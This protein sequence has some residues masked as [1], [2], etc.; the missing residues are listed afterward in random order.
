VSASRITR[1]VPTGHEEAPLTDD[2]MLSVLSPRDRAVPC[3]RVNFVTTLDG[4]STS[5]GVSGSLGGPADGRVFDL[6]RRVTDVVV[7][8]AG[9]V[10]DEGY[11]AMRLGDDAV[12]WR[13][14]AGLAPQPVF[15]LVS[16]SLRLD[17][18]S[19]VFTEAPVRPLVLTTARADA[20]ARRAL[21][22]VADVV[23]CGEERVDPRLL[24]DA[25]VERGLPQMHCE[26][27]P[28]LFGDLVRGDAVDELFLTLAPMLEGGHG[29]RV[30]QGAD[31]E[32]SSPLR[33]L[34]LA[35]VLQDGD[36]LLTWYVRDRS[37]DDGS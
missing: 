35:H 24:R 18:A 36:E 6:L 32:E 10:R 13:E 5:E 11:G 20:A 21:E 14:H 22:R 2:E 9:T 17:P 7:V 15:A 37:R 25:L 23:V 27:G 12:A 1:V 26:G 4:A 29:L 30:S 19:T 28:R 8:G 31:G 33:R 16:A 3:L 34:R